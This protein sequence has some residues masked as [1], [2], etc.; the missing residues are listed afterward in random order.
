MGTPI[1]GFDAN[2]YTSITVK[3]KQVVAAQEYSVQ[4]GQI[5]KFGN[6]LSCTI[7]TNGTVTGLS[8]GSDATCAYDS[9][10]KEFTLTIK[11]PYG[12]N[13]ANLS[14]TAA[15]F[16]LTAKSLDNENGGTKAETTDTKQVWTIGP[17]LADTKS[18]KDYGV[19]NPIS[20]TI[21]WKK[22][23]GAKFYAVYRM[24]PEM[25]GS[26][27]EGNLV[28]VPA[29]LDVYTVSEDGTTVT[30]VGATVTL[31]DDTFTMT[32]TY[33]ANG[34]D[35]QRRLSLGL[36]YT[37]T[38]LPVLKSDD[39]DS[40]IN[41]PAEWKIP[42]VSDG[43]STNKTYN[44]N[45]HSLKNA[46][47]YTKGFGLALE[48]T[49][50]EYPNTVRLSW[51][52][53]QSALDKKTN[54]TIYYRVKGSDSQWTKIE[55]LAAEDSSSLKTVDVVLAPK[56]ETEKEDIDCYKATEDNDGD[57]TD[58]GAK[59]TIPRNLSVTA[60][61]YAVSYSTSNDTMT[62][63]YLSCATYQSGLKNKKFTNKEI[64]SVGYMFSLPPI[65]PTKQK[66]NEKFTEQ[67]Q[68]RSYA[69]G[70][71]T[72]KDAS[73]PVREVGNDIADYTLALQ[74]LNCSS[75]WYTLCQYDAAGTVTA[76]PSYPGWY[77]T[78]ITPKADN[79]V[80][81]TPNFTAR[82]SNSSVSNYNT[83][84]YHDGLL[85]VQRD[86][87]H[88]YR[89]SATR[90]N[91][92][93]TTITARSVDYAYRKITEEEC[94]KAIGL[95]CADAM[96]Q[97]GIPDQS[98]IGKTVSRN[99]GTFK[100]SH[101]TWAGFGT[102]NKC[103]IE[104]SGYCHIFPRT[105]GKQTTKLTSGWTVDIAAELGGDCAGTKLK[106]LPSTEISCTHATG[107]ASYTLESYTVSETCGGAEWFPYDF[108]KDHGTGES[109]LNTNLPTYKEVWWE[110]R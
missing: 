110:V 28:T 100:L 69:Y 11:K 26:D 75:A 84:T 52:L 102:G 45:Q 98:D 61:E 48:A 56:E 43:T 63:D 66:T 32:D 101:K 38:V 8:V 88:Y 95:I 108:G 1:L 79:I 91:S 17:A 58:N 59:V 4:L 22:L 85:K 36:P 64:M 82:T 109:S 46:V 62:K 49:K 5:G 74:N 33:S 44:A 89:I 92:Q 2:S 19:V 39:I 87:K 57:P 54:P 34:T 10:T 12:W 31:T 103:K 6:K 29:A 25:T 72:G 96:H 20:V 9:P 55:T 41:D 13:D 78:T 94:K 42:E 35:N 7:S 81:I 93:G 68:W 65:E 97:V 106:E 90:T 18:T 77:D 3:W 53:P 16:V 60:L 24:R 67:I 50:A 21:T 105:P 76:T 71:G 37:Y 107:L 104:A 80:T 83:T 70:E 73:R 51:E 47:G 14:G 40:Y 86:Y 15:D 23:K 99:L 30:P 27:S